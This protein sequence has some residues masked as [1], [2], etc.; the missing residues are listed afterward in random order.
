[1]SLTRRPLSGAPLGTPIVIAGAPGTTIHAFDQTGVGLGGPFPQRITL[2]VDNPT[3]G[4]LTLT[5]NINGVAVALAVV[6]KT[7]ARIFDSQPMLASATS[8][9]GAVING[10]GSGAG[11]VV[12]GFIETQT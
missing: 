12:W 9:T 5:I 4:D 6:A 7:F 1:M 10:T 2:W 3:A 8:G 11:L